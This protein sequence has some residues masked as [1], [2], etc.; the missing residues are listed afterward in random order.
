MTLESTCVENSGKDVRNFLE[1]Q[2]ILDFVNY[3]ISTT[4]TQQQQL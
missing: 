3:Y 2:N 1:M 4:T